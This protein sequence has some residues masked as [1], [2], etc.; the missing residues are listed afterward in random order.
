MKMDKEELIA[1]NKQQRE[2]LFAEDQHQ[3]EKLVAEEKQQGEKLIFDEQL[4]REKLVTEVILHIL[5]CHENDQLLICL[6]EI[7][8]ICPSVHC[9]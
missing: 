3:R 1:E 4:K 7:I 2:K 5:T 8:A 9:C 6:S